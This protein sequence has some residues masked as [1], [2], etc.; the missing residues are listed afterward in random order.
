MDI[1]IAGQLVARSFSRGSA[2]MVPLCL[3]RVL[4][5]IIGVRVMLN[6]TGGQTPFHVYVYV[7]Y[8][9]YEEIPC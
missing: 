9:R 5:L 7:H 1:W 8:R 6:F 3:F 2:L 4:T